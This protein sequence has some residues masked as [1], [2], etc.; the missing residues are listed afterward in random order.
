LQPHFGGFSWN[1]LDL[2]NIFQSF[3]TPA[4]AWELPLN[5]DAGAGRARRAADVAAV[6]TGAVEGA[7]R[8]VAA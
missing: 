3:P 8:G 5:Q 4:S 7:S 1:L 6:A 2:S